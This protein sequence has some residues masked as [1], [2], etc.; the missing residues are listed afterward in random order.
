VATVAFGVAGCGWYYND[1]P[2]PDDLWHRIPWFDHMLGSRAVY[3]YSTAAV[4]RT[5]VPGTVPVGVTEVDYFPQWQRGNTQRADGLVNP[6]TDMPASIARGDSLYQTFCLPCHGQTGIGDGLVGRK[7]G[8]MSLQTAR[9]RGL[10][11]GYLYSMIRYGRGL[12]GQY[13]DKIYRPEDRW[14][15]VNYV[16]ALQDRA[17]QSEAGQ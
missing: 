12:M 9:A 16:R 17:A 5:T 3:P 13:G 7:M 10:S 14:A 15:V 4:P 1:V 8:S 2:S 11:D 6:T